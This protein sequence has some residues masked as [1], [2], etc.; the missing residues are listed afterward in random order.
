MAIELYGSKQIVPANTSFFDWV[1]ITNDLTSD[2]SSVVVTIDGVNSGNVSLDGTLTSTELRAD[3]V[4]S[5]AST[6]QVSSNTLFQGGST[7]TVHES[8]A[9]NVNS[10]ISFVG[11]T[12]NL[13]VNNANTTI[14]SNNLLI[15]SANTTIAGGVVF[16][17][18]LEVADIVI[19]GNLSVSTTVFGGQ[20]VFEDLEV[21]GNLDIGGVLSSDF[22]TSPSGQF[23][24]FQVI[25]NTT[26]NNVVATGNVSVLNLTSTGTAATKVSTGTT[27]QRP[28]AQSGMI[29][30]N[31]SLSTFE[32]YN[33]AEWGELGGG[34]GLGAPTFIFANYTAKGDDFL[35][36]DTSSGTFTITLPLSPAAGTIIKI[37]G[38]NWELNNLIIA[39]NGSTIENSASNLILD[40]NNVTTEFIY[41]GTTWRVFT[42]LGLTGFTGS[43]GAFSNITNDTST[44]STRFV[45]FVDQTSGSEASVFVSSSKLTFNPST[46]SLNATEFNSLSDVAY[47][48]DIREIDNADDL[49]QKINTYSFTWKDSGLKSYG[50]LAQELE[51]LMPELINNSNGTKYVNYTPLIAVLL[52]GYKSLANKIDELTNEHK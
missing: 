33:G 13:F 21:T 51:E 10:N 36:A 27:A 20:T 14:I 46:G 15:D 23:T 8:T 37:G 4:K 29:R 30:F 7:V 31:T 18:I 6:L 50:V 52:E 16:T 25:A 41:T 39:R 34:G 44:N 9:L 11:P 19:T 22:V 47:K 2:M 42:N 17:G 26:L 45:T 5:R 40:I 3:F 38:I 1:Q 49:L 12:K 32:G 35:V 43:S 28:S 48:D 24:N